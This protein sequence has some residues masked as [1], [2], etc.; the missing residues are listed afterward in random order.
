MPLGTTL[1]DRVDAEVRSDARAQADLV[2]ASAADLL[3]DTRAL[4]KLA[5]NAGQAVRGRVIV[6]DREGILL[7]D[8]EGAPA[9]R[10]YSTRPEIRAALTGKADQRQRDSA[11]LGEPILATAVP[12]LVRARPGGAVR[13]TQS[14]A[15]VDRAV[16]RAWLGLGLVGLIVVAVGLGLGWLIASWVA[17]PTVELDA[18][19]RRVAEGDLKVRATESGSAEQRSLARTFNE[20]TA[21]IGRLL[22]S[23]KEF[24]ADASHQLRT[25][26]AGLRLRLEA[27]AA[28]TESASARE[29]LEAAEHEVDRLA[30]MVG[31]LL[32]LSRVGERELP[33]ERIDLDEAA[34]RACVRWER[35]AAGREL[36]VTTGGGEA[37]MARADLDRIVDAFVENALRYGAGTVTISTSAD[38]VRVLDE[39]PGLHPGEEETV[40]ER[41]HRGSASRDSA[42]GTGL[43]LPIARELA[44]RWGAEVRLRNRDDGLGAV[45]E[46]RFA[47]PLPEGS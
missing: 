45:A 16:Q 36:R 27:A 44:R 13:V 47:N 2:A 38:A 21:R 12:V 14:V 33:G 5:S 39:G 20:M 3:D 19:A 22:D 15:A 4:Q 25:P 42:T 28:E 17:K 8:S 30:Q 26:L 46:L 32:E 40:F 10:D 18:A 37:F 7:A 41:F 1:A 11:T 35:T 43:G 9:G 31:E 23:Q 6:V 34:E 24:V 29:E